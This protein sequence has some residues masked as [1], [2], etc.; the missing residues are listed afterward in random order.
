MHRFDQRP[1]RLRINGWLDAM[2]KVEDMAWTGAK[3]SK[4]L[5]SLLSNTF[6]GGIQHGRIKIALQRHLCTY[7][8]ARV[9]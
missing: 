2:A 4:H 5:R 9:A 7:S 1:D 3:V 6:R 8:P